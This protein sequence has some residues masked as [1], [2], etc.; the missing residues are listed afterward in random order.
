MHGHD[1]LIELMA[2]V[3]V[4]QICNFKNHN[5]MTTRDYPKDVFKFYKDQK[6]EWRW[7]RVADNNRTVGASTEGY[8]NYADCYENAERNGLIAGLHTIESEL[9]K[10]HF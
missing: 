6:N 4:D 7:K 10:S 8:K 2:D 5:T 1:S 9:P 3:I